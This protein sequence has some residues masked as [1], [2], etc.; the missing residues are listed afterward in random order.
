MLGNFLYRFKG[1]VVECRMIAVNLFLDHVLHPDKL[2]VFQKLNTAIYFE[3][4]T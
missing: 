1:L 3:K 2:N 4:K